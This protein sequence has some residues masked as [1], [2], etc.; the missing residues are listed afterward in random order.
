MVAVATAVGAANEA[1]ASRHMPRALA[2]QLS[3]KDPETPRRGSVKD[4]LKQF[5]TPSPSG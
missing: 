3:D 1:N 5:E 4:L 2:P